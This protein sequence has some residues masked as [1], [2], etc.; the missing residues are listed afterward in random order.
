MIRILRRSRSVCVFRPRDCW[1]ILRYWKTY[2]RKKAREF[3]GIVKVGRTQL[4]DAVPMTLEQEFEGFAVALSEDH[5]SFKE[6]CGIC[7]KSTLG[8]TAIGTGI[9]ADPHY[10]EAVRNISRRLPGMTSSLHST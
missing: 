6:S 3:T 8:A 5:D 10:A 2:F 4:Q 9:A 7:A 1:Q